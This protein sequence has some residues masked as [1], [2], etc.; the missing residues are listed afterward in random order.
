MKR[1]I[2][3]IIF[4]CTLSLSAQQPDSLAN[5]TPPGQRLIDDFPILRIGKIPDLNRDNWKL[6]VNGRVKKKLKL[7]F[8]DLMALDT[9]TSV[10]DF[11]CVTTW[12]RLDNHW[13]GV[14]IRTLLEAAGLK[15]D[16]RFLTFKSADGYS[17]S[18]P[19]E[20]CTGDDD[21]LAFRWEGVDLTAELGGPVRCVIPGKYGYKSAMWV[22]SIKATARDEL[23]YWEKRG[24]SNS[25]DPWK[26]ERSAKK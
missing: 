3:P 19:I 14:R 15:K 1:L 21:M 20:L 22:T 11:H 13:T 8:G 18:L 16:A 26:E 7:R 12:S 23:G 25:A 6:K 9:L 24:Y 4:F 17:T 2:I 5:R 10:S